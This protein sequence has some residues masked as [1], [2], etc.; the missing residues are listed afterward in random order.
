MAMKIGGKYKPDE[1]FCRHWYRLV[2][3][4]AIARKNLLKQIK[5]MAADC[6]KKS[7]ELKQTLDREEIHSS[8]FDDI[9]AVIEKRA[10]SITTRIA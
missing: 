2:A 8:I 10:N 1:L 4:T 6:Q 9:M 7:A 5:K 3:D